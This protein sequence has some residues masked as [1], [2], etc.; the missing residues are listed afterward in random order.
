MCTLSDGKGI[1][2]REN[3]AHCQ[4]ENTC[5][6]T[7]EPTEEEA[8]T[9]YGLCN[10]GTL[11]TIAGVPQMHFH[12]EAPSLEAAIRSAIVDVRAGGFAVE[13]VEI[14]PETVMQ[15]T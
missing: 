1:I 14:E 2:D 4:G 10:D 8:D 9:L 15:L 6:L 13:R 5:H 7:A 3:P 11:S 12:R